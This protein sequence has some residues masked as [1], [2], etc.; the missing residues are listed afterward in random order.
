M[1]DTH[2]T[3]TDTDHSHDEHALAHPVPMSLLLGIFG[4][5]MVLTVATVAVTKF[6]L[7]VFNIWVA[8][9]IAVIKA[10]LVA[11]Y[12]MH[13]RWDSPFNGIILIAS[14]FFVAIFIGTAILDSNQYKPNLNPLP[15]RSSAMP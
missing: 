9:G 14:L 15:A 2:N 5:L 6:D 7:G 3:T 11:M 8:L 1:S 10:G 12:F 13:L 4:I